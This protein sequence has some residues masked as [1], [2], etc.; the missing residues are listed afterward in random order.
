MFAGPAS[1]SYLIVLLLLGAKPIPELAKGLGTD[2]K[3]PRREIS[4][5]QDAEVGAPESGKVSGETR[6]GSREEA[7]QTVGAHVRNRDL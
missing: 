4:D 7:V 2:V 5:D 3:E 1:S 6:G